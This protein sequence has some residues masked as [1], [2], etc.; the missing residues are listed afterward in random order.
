MRKKIAVF[1]GE[2]GR[3]FQKSF[4]NDIKGIANS[5]GYDVFIFNNFGSYSNTM[6]FDSGERDV[7]NI[8]V[9]SE[10]VGVI[11]LADTY[12]IAGMERL[13]IDRIKET[14]DCPIISIRNGAKDTYRIVFDDFNTTYDMTKH[15]INQHGFKK[16][17]YMSGPFSVEDS[18]KR[19][20]GFKAAMIDSGLPITD[21]II[22]EGDFWKF[23]SK[24]AA[25]FFLKSYNG[26]PQAIICANDY[27]ALGLSEEL[28]SR[29]IRIPEDIAISGFDEVTE[30][31]GSTP[32]LT[33]VKTPITEMATKAVEI[34][35]SVRAGK[36][37]PKESFLSGKPLF[38]ASC[39][40]NPKAPKLDIS[41]LFHQVANDYVNV[42]TATFIASD[43]Q[44]R[45]TESDK[46]ALINEFA[47]NFK[48]TK[49]Y[50]CLCTGEHK[51]DNPYSEKM[52]LRVTFPY[53]SSTPDYK[54]E[55]FDRKHIL[56]ESVY[57]SDEPGC[58]IVLPIHQKNI[59]FGYLVSE[60]DEKQDFTIFIAPVTAAI[61]T[62]YED[63]RM[64]EEFKELAEIRRQNLIDTLTGI[65]NR[66]A[67]EQRLS[68]LMAN[69]E[70]NTN[71]ISF[72]SADLDNLKTINDT[73]GHHEGD[74]AIKAFANGIVSALNPDDICAR[75]G[76]DEFYAIVTSPD[77][78]FHK[79]IIERINKELE[80]QS[81]KLSKPYEIFASV[82][83]CTVDK[84]S[85]SNAFEHLEVADKHMYEQ[86]R[87]HKKK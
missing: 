73:F 28:K 59:T 66:R 21:D 47:P 19:L 11:S 3:E 18:V 8:P 15:F 82:G 14:S 84:D 1:L 23:L 16:I 45:A 22:F 78:E 69:K 43:V 64:Q 44:N 79:T 51:D 74:I 24:P 7:I 2:I 80:I 6:L 10:F 13:L 85:L 68:S 42:R 5:K 48:F 33:T 39:G 38:K 86:K 27:M 12:D 17:C 34:I 55:L 76:G 26:K 52:N 72:V 77:E 67:F 31:R 61:A 56:P 57:D 49:S 62:A 20:N 81:E 71:F 50:L 32:V 40:C 36:E 58:F 41:F 54:D 83:V 75:V 35:E 87:L 29:G 46:L 37:V 4:A 70:L 63:L 30:G 60:W 65:S 53:E 25:D 9:F